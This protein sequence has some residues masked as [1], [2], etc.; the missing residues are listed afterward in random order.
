MA[1]IT[2]II[3]GSVTALGIAIFLYL[4]LH[5]VLEYQRIAVFS[6]GRFKRIAGP[7]LI[8]MNPIWERPAPWPTLEDRDGAKGLIDLREQTHPF[9]GQDCLTKDHVV[10][11]VAPVVFHKVVDPARAVVSIANAHLA[12]DSVARATLRAVVGDMELAEV[13]G[14]REHVA[15]TLKTRIAAEAERWGIHVTNV[16]IAALDPSEDVKRAMDKRK[17][18]VETA[19]GAA[20][21]QIIAAN[22]ARDAAHAQRD[23]DVTRA[24]SEK[25]VAI[26]TAEG[27]KEAAIRQAEGERE[28][29]MLRAE[30][31]AAYYKT[32]RELGD[33]SATVLKFETTE[34]FK[35]LAR[36]EN[37]KLVMLPYEAIH[38]GGS[39]ANGFAN[40][41]VMEKDMPERRRVQ[42]TS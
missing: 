40:L 35:M 18:D 20:R 16:E 5:R 27:A 9:E 26:L 14:R 41:D 30:G 38:F 39:G 4:G 33:A 15:S 11:T 3:I 25:R 10:V 8:F 34:A 19:H 7:G 23:A 17:A 37:S 1:A 32:L 36:S 13:M 2:W 42:V 31:L 21:A 29:Q 28:A 6:F 12:I 22:A 24:E